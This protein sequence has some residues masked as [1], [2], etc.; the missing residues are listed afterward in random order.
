MTISAP[1]LA[2]SSTVAPSTA[3]LSQAIKR[4]DQAARGIQTATQPPPAIGTSST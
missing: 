1:A 4:V 3:G 2:S